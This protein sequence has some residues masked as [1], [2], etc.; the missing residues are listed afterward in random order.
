M[1]SWAPTGMGKGGRHL[2]Y[3]IVIEICTHQQCQMDW[4]NL[5]QH[6]PCYTP[7]TVNST[8]KDVVLII[9]RSVQLTDSSKFLSLGGLGLRIRVRDTIRLGCRSNATLVQKIS[10]CFDQLVKLSVSPTKRSVTWH[11]A[12]SVWSLFIPGP[13]HSWS[14]S[15]KRTLA[16]LLPGTFALWN[17]RSLDLELSFSRVFA[18]RTFVPC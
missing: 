18:P 11:T 9:T 4:L 7:P 14:E 17:F 6:K 5:Q 15:S 2:Q 16:N 12:F 8:N 13:I 3:C 1:L 10:G